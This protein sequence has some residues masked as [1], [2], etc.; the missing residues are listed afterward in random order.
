MTR[1][2]M[3]TCCGLVL[4][5]SPAA[6]HRHRGPFENRGRFERRP[7]TFETYTTFKAGGYAPDELAAD[8]RGDGGLFLGVEWGISP[9]PPIE[10]GLTL[11]WFH[12]DSARG[13]VVVFDGPYDLPVEVVTGE[14]SSTDLV[15]LGAV[16]RGRF[17]VGDGRVLPFVAGHL[18]YDVLHLEA[19]GA[20][21]EG[22]IGEALRDTNYFSGLGAGFSMG[23]EADLAPGFGLL[24]EAGIHQTEPGRQIRVGG[25]PAEARVNADGEYLRAGARF[26][27]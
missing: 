24:V 20:S 23:V 19:N 17:P 22:E 8:A 1:I 3:L 26:A 18:T 14:A 21:W 11:D 5:A 12:R 2:A 10:V 7:P 27:F 16:V 4:S 15:P 25:L 13:S 9:A 6:A